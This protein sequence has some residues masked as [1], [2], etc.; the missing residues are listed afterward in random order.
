MKTI[1]LIFTILLFS[2]TGCSNNTSQENTNTNSTYQ[3]EKQLA[4][5]PN[6]TNTTTNTT[7]ELY[8]Y[9]TTIYTKTDAR[10]NNVRLCCD[11]LNGQVVSS[12]ETFSF[13]DTLRTCNS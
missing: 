1:I 13:C 8:R 7:T 10:Q 5:T 9:S 2:L 6:N 11:E 12:G 3:A 4:Q